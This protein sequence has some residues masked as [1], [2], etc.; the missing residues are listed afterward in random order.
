[1]DADLD[2]EDAKIITLARSAYARGAGAAGGAAVRDETGRTHVAVGVNL[3]S[4]SLTALQLAVAIAI[5][6]GAGALEAAAVVQKDGDELLD[7]ELAVAWETKAA[8]VLVAGPDG[9]LARVY[10]RPPA[11]AA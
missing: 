6:S 4:V 1:M 11:T 10:E 8:H 9:T 7:A 5:S 3:E 2:P